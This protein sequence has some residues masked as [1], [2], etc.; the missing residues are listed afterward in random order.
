MGQGQEVEVVWIAQDLDPS[1][2][3]GSGLARQ[4]ALDLCRAGGQVLLLGMG[5]HAGVYGMAG[6]KLAQ[7]TEPLII[8]VGNE[9]LECADSLRSKQRERA[10]G[11]ATDDAETEERCGCQQAE[12][13]SADFPALCLI[14]LLSRYEWSW[15]AG[16][17]FVNLLN[18][19]DEDQLGAVGNRKRDVE[20]LI[21]ELAAALC[22]VR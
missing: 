1:V 21:Q 12:E 22:A 9:Y 4:I 10:H 15:I 8:Y 14:W 16:S 7:A 5:Q 18:F 13:V 11:P 19:V 2:G 20:P 17:W 6:T 3:C